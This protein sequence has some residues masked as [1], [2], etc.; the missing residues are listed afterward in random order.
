MILLHVAVF[1]LARHQIVAGLPDFKIFYTAGTMLRRGQG[2]ALYSNA[3]QLETQREFVPLPP[4]ATIPLPYNHP[5][6]EALLFVPITYLS[7]IHA[8]CLWILLNLLL[9]EICIYVIRPWLPVLTSEFPWLLFLAPLVF[10][11]VVFTFMQ[12]QDSILLLAFYCLAYAA[13]RRGRDVQAGI[14]LGLSLCKFHLVVPFGVVLLL[15]RRWRAIGGMLLSAVCEFLVSWGIVGWKELCYYPLYVWHV[16]REKGVRMIIPEQMPN[17]RGLF[18][19]WAGSVAAA[20]WLELLLL[21]ASLGLLLWSSRRWQPGSLQDF[22]AWNA[23][24]SIAMTVT[25]LVGYHG[26]NHDM[27]ILLL[28][29]LLILDYLLSEDAVRATS[30]KVIVGLMFVTPLY[31]LLTVHYKHENLFSLILL[32]FVVSLARL[33]NTKSGIALEAESF[34]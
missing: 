25:F 18:I 9:A 7:Y 28:P 1:W 19:G 24:F 21:A 20:P 11:P 10:F 12:G 27:A 2:Q 13:F 17:L 26:Y 6:F 3:L 30:L 34:G 8:Y 14:W 15:H 29:A 4:N 22:R 33:S 5:P 32:A 16:N 31:L 23:G